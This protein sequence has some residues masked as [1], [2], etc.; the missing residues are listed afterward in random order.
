MLIASDTYTVT[1]AYTPIAIFIDGVRVY[2]YTQTGTTITFTTAVLRGSEVLLMPSDTPILIDT[3]VT[4]VAIA[5]VGRRS[6][7]SDPFGELE[8]SLDQVTWTKVVTHTFPATV[9]IKQ[10]PTNSISISLAS[11]VIWNGGDHG[12]INED[13]FVV[14]TETLPPNAV[15]GGLEYYAN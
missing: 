7:F 15:T 13:G 9:Y 12:S 10:T 4:S 5:D 1:C 2:N 14:I 6:I 3:E 11:F 8:F